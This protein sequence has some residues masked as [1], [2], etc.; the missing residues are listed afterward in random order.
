MTANKYLAIFVWLVFLSISL[1]LIP[2]H[3][4]WRDELQAW[5]I[6]R[7]SASVEELFR[8]LKYEGHPG[9]W[10][11]FLYS[12]AKLFSTPVAMQYF[13]VLI[14]SCT[15]FVILRWSPFSILQKILLSFGY[16]FFYEYSQIARN[17]ALGVLLIFIACALFPKR[18]DHPIVIATVLFLLSHTS[19]FGLIFSFWLFLTI[20][21]EELSAKSAI[22]SFSR[23]A[24]PYWIASLIVVVGIITSIAQLVPPEDSGFAVAWRFY[25]SIGG[26]KSVYA[27]FIGAY[28]PIPNI[29][30]SYWNSIALISNPIYGVISFIGITAVVYSVSRYL[31]SKPSAFFLYISTTVTLS[32]FFYTKYS[33]SLRHHGF[34]FISLVSALWIYSACKEQNLLFKASGFKGASSKNINLLITLLFAVHVAAGLTVVVLDIKNQFSGAKQTANFLLNKGLSNA[35]IIGDSSPAASAV[36]G[37]L[38]NKQFYFIDGERHGTF[39]RWDKSRLNTTSTQSL[40]DASHKFSKDSN[41][42]VLV[43][44]YKIRDG[45]ENFQ[46]I[47]E[48]VDPV[49]ADE[50]FFVYQF[51]PQR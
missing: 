27:S 13:H 5:L 18:K 37:F 50:K 47:Y 49:V 1:C 8:N 16:F 12:I 4:M 33:G 22:N 2:Y 17:Y 36:A 51:K 43:V 46:M 34:L 11:F 42:V 38:P 25:P 24:G 48:S 15:V 32:L 26:I 30:L 6:A 20:W 31:I 45:K 3:E 7:D 44:N 23:Y 29:N 40:Y 10:H 35:F 9:L 21:Y 19:V 14:A 39:I 28:F 41:V